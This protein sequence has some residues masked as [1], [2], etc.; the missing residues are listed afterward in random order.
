MPTGA[1][2]FGPSNTTALTFS[3]ATTLGTAIGGWTFNPGASAYTFSIVT[4]FGTPKVITFTGAGIV[5]NGGSAS[6]TDTGVLNFNANI[7]AG[8]AAITAD[9]SGDLN[10]NNS[11]TAGSATFTCSRPRAHTESGVQ[12]L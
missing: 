1:A 3:P 9:A 4:N 6:I 2:F 10:F 11:S 12:P 8:N 7:K 5:T